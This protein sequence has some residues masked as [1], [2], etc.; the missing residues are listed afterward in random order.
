MLL[1]WIQLSVSILAKAYSNLIGSFVR[2]LMLILLVVLLYFCKPLMFADG[3]EAIFSAKTDEHQ[4]LH[5]R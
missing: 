1:L 3:M 4:R 2:A 5:D